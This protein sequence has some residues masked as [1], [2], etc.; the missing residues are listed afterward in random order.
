MRA[1]QTYVMRLLADTEDAQALRGTLG[2]VTDGRDYSFGDEGAF[3]RLLH[4]LIQ[5]ALD[6]QPADGMSGSRPAPHD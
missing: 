4:E 6:T 5:R 3:L 1:V 2:C